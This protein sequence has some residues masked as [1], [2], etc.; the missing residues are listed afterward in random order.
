[1][2]NSKNPFN[3]VVKEEKECTL[4]RGKSREGWAE[5]L[6]QHVR[7][8]KEFKQIWDWGKK[9]STWIQALLRDSAAREPRHTLP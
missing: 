9:T 1:M 8:L 3:D 7:G 4:A 5:K 2:K 6:I